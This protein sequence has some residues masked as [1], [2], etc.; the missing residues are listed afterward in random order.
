MFISKSNLRYFF[1]N[2]STEKKNASFSTSH[3]STLEGE[4]KRTAQ[5]SSCLPGPQT[6]IFVTPEHGH[7][8]QCSAVM[9]TSAKPMPVMQRQCLLGSQH[10]GFSFTA[11][12]TLYCNN[13]FTF[14]YS[15]SSSLRLNSVVAGQH[16]SLLYLQGLLTE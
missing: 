8:P 13:F 4:I 7:L 15:S 9:I 3:L 10:S 12:V 11:P 2:K 14:L 1:S 6:Q 16:W 5:R